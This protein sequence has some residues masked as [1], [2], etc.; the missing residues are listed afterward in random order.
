MQL[1]MAR[2]MECQVLLTACLLRWPPLL[3]QQAPTRRMATLTGRLPQPPT[4]PA[5]LPREWLL[6][7]RRHRLLTHSRILPLTLSGRLRTLVPVSTGEIHMPPRCLR[8]TPLLA[9]LW[10]RPPPLP[11]WWKRTVSSA[12]PKSPAYYRMLPTPP[13]TAISASFCTARIG[14]AAMYAPR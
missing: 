13:S 11:P 12:R 9:L 7:F 5:C 14:T 2:R 10:R 4:Q 1:R 3:R 8:C 6:M